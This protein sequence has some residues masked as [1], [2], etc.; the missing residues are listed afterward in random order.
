MTVFGGGFPLRPLYKGGPVSIPL[1]MST[2]ESLATP[3]LLL[4]P[5][6]PETARAVV[7]GDLSSLDPVE[8]WPHQDTIDG[9]SG[10]VKYGWPAGWMVTLDGKVIGDC[11]THGPA[12]AQGVIEIGYGLAADYRGRG[13]GTEMVGAISRWLLEARDVRAVIASTLADNISSRRVL[14]KNGFGFT[15]FDDEGQALYRREK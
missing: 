8:G 14:E 7:D 10:P 2:F 12:D 5:F 13:F 9:L 15:G 1:H 6:D 11:G 4:V 3:R